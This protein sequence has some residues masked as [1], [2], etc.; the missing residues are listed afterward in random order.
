[1]GCVEILDSPHEG[2]D[3]SAG[4]LALPFPRPCSGKIRSVAKRGRAPPPAL[5]PRL[6]SKM[7]RGRRMFLDRGW[8]PPTSDAGIWALDR[9]LTQPLFL[10]I[11]SVQNLLSP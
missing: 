2:C 9:G 8:T 11:F 3:G 4:G 6:E 5:R 1:M 10:V 7:W